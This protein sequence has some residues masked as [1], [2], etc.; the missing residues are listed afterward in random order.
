MKLHKVEN[1]LLN[2]YRMLL[3]I[4]KTR[5]CMHHFIE[6]VKIKFKHYIDEYKQLKGDFKGGGGSNRDAAA[7]GKSTRFN[8]QLI[9]SGGEWVPVIDTGN[10]FFE[11]GD[12]MPAE[13]INDITGHSYEPYHWYYMD[14][15]FRTRNYGLQEFSLQFQY[16]NENLIYGELEILME[17]GINSGEPARSEGDNIIHMHTNW[18]RYMVDMADKTVCEFLHYFLSFPF[19]REMILDEFTSKVKPLLLEKFNGIVNDGG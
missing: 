14:R 15:H 6:T 4:P 10:R 9:F 1:E 18:Q 8:F 3:E 19:Y 5:E 11:I 7:A 16:K 17:R 12:L 13:L 2:E